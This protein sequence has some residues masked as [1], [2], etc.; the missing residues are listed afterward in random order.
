[1]AKVIITLEDS[2]D[3][4]DV[5]TRVVFDPQIENPLK[6]AKLTG[7]QNMGWG[8]MRAIMGNAKSA[9]DVEVNDGEED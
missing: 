3:G 8:L 9:D 7:A 2:D 1:M 6:G 4:Q 5:E